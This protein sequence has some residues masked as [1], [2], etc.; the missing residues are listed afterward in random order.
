MKVQKRALKIET[1][2]SIAILLFCTGCSASSRV[3]DSI[4]KG[5]Y[6]TAG[7]LYSKNVL[8]N[9]NLESE[10]H[11]GAY[12]RMDAA[13]DGYNQG[14]KTYEAEKAVLETIECDTSDVREKYNAL[15]E[16]SSSK[17]SY[18]FGNEYIAN[19]DY[20]NAII[21]YGQVSSK[22]TNYDAAQLAKADVAGKFKEAVLA[23]AAANVA[24][25]D[26]ESALRT[27]Q[28][29]SRIL[30][31]DPD[32]TSYIEKYKIAYE[33]FEVEQLL[34]EASALGSQEKYGEAYQLLNN[35]QNE[36]SDR[37]EIESA[38]SEYKAKYK[39][40]MIKQ[41]EAALIGERDYHKAF[42]IMAQA[43]IVLSDDSDFIEK[44][45][46][47]SSFE[48]IWLGDVEPFLE[49]D[50]NVGFF[51]AEG[52]FYFRDDGVTDN[53]GNMY[54]NYFYALR[55]LNGGTNSIVYRLDGNYDTLTGTIVVPDYQKNRDN[56]GWYKIYCDN[57]L[58]FDSGKLGKGVLPIDVNI[59]L[60]DVVELKIEIHSIAYMSGGAYCGYFADAYLKKSI[61][62]EN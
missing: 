21:Q 50:E 47:Y 48:P 30:G 42:S 45:E 19:G 13:I 44:Q 29:A 54:E 59:S 51:G 55:S 18:N 8:G 5:N 40:S 62:Q 4:D 41:A 38:V 33:D 52:H 28:N 36:F 56:I 57:K 10:V 39:E 3:L 11:D 16:L 53:V 6:I 58:V 35:K 17:N 34:Q 32:L 2:L 14:E 20:E 9:Y 43:L 22:D 31:S 49:Q 1:I 37:A 27:L 60:T 12:T 7:E 26:Y 15:D 25:S 23:E 24:A 46:Y 61:P